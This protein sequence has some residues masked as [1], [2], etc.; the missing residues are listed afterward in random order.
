MMIIRTKNTSLSKYNLIQCCFREKALDENTI[1]DLK[2]TREGNE[3]AKIVPR[4]D[5]YGDIGL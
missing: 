5:S 3:I 1:L 4:I 2:L